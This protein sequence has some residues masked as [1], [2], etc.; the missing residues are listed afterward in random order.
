LKS[1]K[2]LAN[3]FP[4]HRPNSFWYSQSSELPVVRGETSGKLLIQIGP[5]P[6]KAGTTG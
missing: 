3:T 2:T 1:R 5:D 6:T 4:G